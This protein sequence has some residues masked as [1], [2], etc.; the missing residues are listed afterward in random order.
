MPATHAHPAANKKTCL[1]SELF[2]YSCATCLMHGRHSLQ[3]CSTQPQKTIQTLFLCETLDLYVLHCWC[4]SSQSAANFLCFF[5]TSSELASQASPCMWYGEGSHFSSA[6]TFIP[7]EVAMHCPLFFPFLFAQMLCWHS[8]IVQDGVPRTTRSSIF[9]G[10]GAAFLNSPAPPPTN[11]QAHT[12]FLGPLL[13]QKDGVGPRSMLLSFCHLHTNTMSCTL[14]PIS[15]SEPLNPQ[16][17]RTPSPQWLDVGR[18]FKRAA[19][20]RYTTKNIAGTFLPETSVQ[21]WP[22]KAQ[23]KVGRKLARQQRAYNT[24]YKGGGGERD[25]VKSQAGVK[26]TCGND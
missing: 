10:F 25:I 22:E 5:S 24:V 2:F 20:C 7:A 3:F 12:G 14:P 23:E 11:N 16:L 19:N 26:T 1:G 6:S 17:W 8:G 9:S 13:K 4:T 15:P 21:R 18:T